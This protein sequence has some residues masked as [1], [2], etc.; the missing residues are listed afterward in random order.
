MPTLPFFS[1]AIGIVLLLQAC[2]ILCPREDPS[3]LPSTFFLLLP[4]VSAPLA[5]LPL[6]RRD[7]PRPR[8]GGAGVPTVFAARHGVPGRRRA[9]RSAGGGR[10]DQCAPAAAVP[11]HQWAACGLPL[12]SHHREHHHA[13]HG[14]APILP[15]EP[16]EG[17]ALDVCRL[18]A[19]LVRRS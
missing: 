7:G 17:K 13:R 12:V 3:I 16:E 5:S 14:A 19:V 11:E 6:P 10:G 8:S 15:G 4:L 9:R 1:C 18:P 2:A